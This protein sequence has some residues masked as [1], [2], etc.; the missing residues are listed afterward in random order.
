MYVVCVYIYICI[1]IVYSHTYTQNKPNKTWQQW[2]DS[3]R[4]KGSEPGFQRLSR[5]MLTLVGHRLN[6]TTSLNQE[7][8]LSVAVVGAGPVGLLTALALARRGFRKATGKKQASKT[9]DDGCLGLALQFLAF[10]S[11][12]RACQAVVYDMSGIGF[13]AT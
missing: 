11:P 6:P 12:Q 9:A 8:G 1:Y 5:E 13:A 7:Q 10:G 3:S 4:L 2:L